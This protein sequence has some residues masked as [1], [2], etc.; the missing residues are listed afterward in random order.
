MVCDGPPTT[1]LASLVLSFQC[2]T[3]KSDVCKQPDPVG[4]QLAGKV[5]AGVVI[6]HDVGTKKN[7]SA[8]G[9]WADLWKLRVCLINIG[10]LRKPM[11]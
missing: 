6:G 4:V 11:D 7:I 1:V 8:S 2:H 10:N 3:Q 5:G 9:R